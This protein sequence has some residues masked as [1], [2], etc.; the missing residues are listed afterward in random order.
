LKG[1]RVPKFHFIGKVYRDSEAGC[2]QIA[3]GET[4]RDA[5]S[6]D[7][8]RGAWERDMRKLHPDGP[9]YNIILTCDIKPVDESVPMTT[10][11]EPE[12]VVEVES[13]RRSQLH[14]FVHY[15][16]A[17]DDINRHCGEPT[18]ECDQVGHFRVKT[19]RWRWQRFIHKLQ[20]AW[21]YG[22]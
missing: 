5:E 10:V 15:N 21:R 6:A 3:Y 8:L 7:A 9:D 12:P 14:F 13:P 22:L 1:K 20:L 18:I 19:P 17:A 2:R 4:V 11:A 16:Y